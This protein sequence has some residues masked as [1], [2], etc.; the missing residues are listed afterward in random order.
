MSPSGLDLATICGQT[1]ERVRTDRSQQS[2]ADPSLRRSHGL[3]EALLREPQEVVEPVAAVDAWPG[4]DH[5]LVEVEAAIED[6]EAAEQGL[7]LLREQLVAPGDGRLEG[8]LPR[9]HIARPRPRER[10]P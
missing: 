7:L 3:D 5:H 9:R 6:G 1:T 2:E 8:A 10:Q 4:H